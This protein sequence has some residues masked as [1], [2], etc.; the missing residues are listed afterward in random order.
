MSA[1]RPPG[2]LP[3]DHPAAPKYWKNET[4]G[5][6]ALAVAAFIANPL[7][8]TEDE[9]HLMRAYC[10]QWIDS[11]AWDGN[12]HANWQGRLVLATLRRNAREIRTPRDLVWWLAVATREG[13]DPL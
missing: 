12:P 2:A 6:L 11:P 1:P 4:S 3:A 5:L 8:I 7:G 10:E 9:V 13:F